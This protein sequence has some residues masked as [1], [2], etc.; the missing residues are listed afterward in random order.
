M[1]SKTRP[2]RTPDALCLT[3]EE[4]EGLSG[5]LEAYCAIF[6]PLF[7]RREQR[8]WMEVY[9]EGLVTPSIERKSIEPM[10]LAIKGADD[11]AV[12]AAQQFIG[13]GAWDDD[14]ILARHRVEVA[15]TMGE[16]DGVLTLD[17]SDFPKQGKESVGVKRQYC[18]QLGKRANCQAG[19]FLGYV[20][21]KGYTLLDRRLYLPKEWVDSPLYAERREKCG[22]PRDL[23]FRT[24]NKLAWDMIESLQREDSLPHRWV[25]CDEAFG[26]DT[27]LLDQIAGSGLWYF[28]EIPKDTRVWV[29]RPATEVPEWKGRGPKPQRSRVLEGQPETQ[30]VEDLA[31]SIAVEDWTRCAI[32]EG[33]KGPIIADF[34]AIQVAAVRE[35]LPGPDVWLVLRRNAETGEVKYFVSN[36]PADTPLSTLVRTAGLRWPIETCFEEGKQY[37]GMGDYEVRTWKGWHHHMTLCLLA[38]HF[39]VR[40][41]QNLKKK[42]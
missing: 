19:V 36:A 5:E 39:L 40:T 24:K 32:K 16:P 11:N 21:S 4:I 3:R 12:R 35:D 31:A 2:D 14:V 9:L 1:A 34:F 18:G 30:G 27:G 37:L 15:V 20:S 10:I 8:D 6:R 42:Q 38:H 33:T 29:G 28:A 17:G 23:E 22:V 13:A 41:Q 25:A 7:A 26:R